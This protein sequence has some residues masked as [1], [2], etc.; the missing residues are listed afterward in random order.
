L[1]PTLEF[2]PCPS[3]GNF[4]VREVVTSTYFFN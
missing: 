3:R 4:D 1:F 2:P